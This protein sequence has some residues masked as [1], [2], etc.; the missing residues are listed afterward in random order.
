MSRDELFS[1]K[2]NHIVDFVFDEQVVAV[3]PDMIRRSVPGYETVIPMT[4]LMA[5]RH[6]TNNDVAYDLGCSLGAT[7]LAILQQTDLAGVNVIGVDNAPAMIDKARSQVTDPRARFECADLTE[8]DVTDAKVVILNFVMQF[9]PLAARTPLLRRL[10]AQMRPDGLL[11]V[12]EKVRQP[13][14]N[15]HERFDATHLAWKRANG[16]SDLEVSQKRQALEN[17]MRVDT[18]EIH[19]RRFREA[20]FTQSTTWFRCLNWASFIATSEPST[21]R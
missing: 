19:E 17:V 6:L 8:F 14:P 16:Y 2:Q 7:T 10:R 18:E 1:A 21:G 9:L 5:A 20:G 12:S 13:D 11:I 15:L 4:G 3:F